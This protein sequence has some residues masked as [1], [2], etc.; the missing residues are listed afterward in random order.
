MFW[1]ASV[2]TSNSTSRFAASS[3]TTARWKSTPF[4]SCILPTF[5]THLSSSSTGTGSSQSKRS[6]HNS[7]RS[8][9]RP[10]V[11]G[12]IRP[13]GSNTPAT[14]PVNV[15]LVNVWLSAALRSPATGS[16]RLPRDALPSL[17]G[18]MSSLILSGSVAQ[19]YPAS[20]TCTPSADTLS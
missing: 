17:T 16:G 3:G 2:A 6:L 12:V 4:S 18:P 9:L 1:L 13:R 10:A 15:R 5:A 7:C 19:R 11:I 8:S 20:P 14:R